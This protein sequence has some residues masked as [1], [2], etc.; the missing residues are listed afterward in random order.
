MMH[1]R[2]HCTF[3]RKG[4]LIPSEVTGQRRG[5]VREECQSCEHTFCMNCTCPGLSPCLVPPQNPKS[6]YSTCHI[7]YLRPV[8]GALNVDEKKN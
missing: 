5:Q 7:E 4:L 2:A 1:L 8:H 6:C 3:D